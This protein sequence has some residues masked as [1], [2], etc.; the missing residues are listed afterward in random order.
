MKVK[1]EE[2]MRSPQRSRQ[3]AMAID[4]ISGDTIVGSLLPHSGGDEMLRF[5]S[6]GLSSS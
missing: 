2:P 5:V 6:S 3:R 1:S 4:D